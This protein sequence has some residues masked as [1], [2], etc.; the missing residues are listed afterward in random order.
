MSSTNSGSGDDAGADE[1]DLG[2]EDEELLR[3][4]NGNLDHHASSIVDETGQE[5]ADDQVTTTD[6]PVSLLDNDTGSATPSPRV[7]DDEL[8]AQR[9]FSPGSLEDSTSLP[10]ET[11]SLHVSQLEYAHDTSLTVELI[12]H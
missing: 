8:H 7:V 4:T 5:K 2:D 12:A 1:I 9:P 3:P 11:P 10:D 6:A